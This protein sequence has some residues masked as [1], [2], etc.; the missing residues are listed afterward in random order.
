MEA[1]RRGAWL[2]LPRTAAGRTP[3]RAGEASGS[4]SP[5]D[6]SRDQ[7]AFAP[8]AG[9]CIVM[10]AVMTVTTVMMS[11][12]DRAMATD[13][14]GPATDRVIVPVGDPLIGAERHSLV[15]VVVKVGAIASL[16]NLKLSAVRKLNEPVWHFAHRGVCRVGR[17]EV[18][19]RDVGEEVGL[20]LSPFARGKEDAEVS[21]EPIGLAG[22]ITAPFPR[23]T[24]MTC[25]L[26]SGYVPGLPLSH[27]ISQASVQVKCTR[28][29][30]IRVCPGELSQLTR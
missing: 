18:G 26:L 21:F 10:V 25:Y 4:A 9:L 28:E 13:G 30:T 19:E 11:F 20:S 22:F 8:L 6:P 1:G 14:A 15:V 7:A 16:V 12:T 27:G 23:P 5:D 29:P 24:V 2:A 17:R 3:P